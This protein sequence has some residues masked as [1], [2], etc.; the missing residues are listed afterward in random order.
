MSYRKGMFAFF[1]GTSGEYRKAL[2]QGGKIASY[3]VGKIDFDGV[4]LQSSGITIEMKVGAAMRLEGG[5]WELR[6]PGEWGEMASTES[7][8][9]TGAV[10]ETT[11][12]S[13]NLPS[14]GDESDVLKRLMEKRQQ[15]EKELK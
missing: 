15:Q 5:S 6:P 7:A 13:T 12:T 9:G 3:T 1:D 10:Q 2:Q 11:E 14:S 8:T 4:Q